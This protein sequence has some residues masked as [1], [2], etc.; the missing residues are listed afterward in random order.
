MLAEPQRPVLWIGLCG[1]AHFAQGCNRRMVQGWLSD[2]TISV[3][4]ER[5][6]L[7]PRK[8]RRNSLSGLWPAHAFAFC[9]GRGV[10]AQK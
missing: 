8:P 6:L 10:A 4:L 3:D 7:A 2:Q 9:L 1:F 5:V